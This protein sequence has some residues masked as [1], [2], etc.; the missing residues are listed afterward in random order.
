[1]IKLT[2]WYQKGVY[3]VGW[4]TTVLMSLAFLVGFIQGLL[5]K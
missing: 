2:H 3:V 4:I 5:E 1:M